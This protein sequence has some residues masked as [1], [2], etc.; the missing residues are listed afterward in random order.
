MQ[1]TKQSM[2]IRIYQKKCDTNRKLE[3]GVMQ[4]KS[5]ACS[6]TLQSNIIS[7]LSDI[8][9]TLKVLIYNI[10]FDNEN[11]CISPNKRVIIERVKE[12]ETGRINFT[13]FYF[14]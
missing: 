9:Q 10:F 2:F 1:L 3:E 8:F 13:H 11:P 5:I 6:V 14:C 7:L 12:I 4:L